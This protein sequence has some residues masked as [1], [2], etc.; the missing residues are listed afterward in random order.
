MRSVVDRNVVITNAFFKSVVHFDA[1]CTGMQYTAISD[2][3]MLQV[4]KGLITAA[5]S[6][7]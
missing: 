4:L 6:L 2:S 3:A 5:M 7:T 1:N